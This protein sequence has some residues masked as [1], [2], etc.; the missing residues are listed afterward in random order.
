MADR[1]E[2][3][4]EVLP[5]AK[6]VVLAEVI[7]AKGGETPAQT[8]RLPIGAAPKCPEQ[9][10]RLKVER[11]LFGPE[12]AEIAALKPAAGYVL[13]PGVKGP[14]LI[15]GSTPVPKVLGR[16]GPDTYTLAVLE[17]ALKSRRE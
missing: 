6:L 15:D 2:P 1:P 4:S 10:V 3:L 17:K 11:T 13:V 12:Q 16:Y 8:R 14:F 9:Q 5:Q 7:E